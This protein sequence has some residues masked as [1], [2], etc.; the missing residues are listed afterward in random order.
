MFELPAR[1]GAGFAKSARDGHGAEKEDESPELVFGC[2]T[3]RVLLGQRTGVSSYRTHIDELRAARS[4]AGGARR[5]LGEPLAPPRA[6]TPRAQG[7]PCGDGPRTARAGRAPALATQ[8]GGSAR[9]GR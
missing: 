6:G 7:G 1:A 3:A 5:R 2:Q 4:I 8:R 9:A